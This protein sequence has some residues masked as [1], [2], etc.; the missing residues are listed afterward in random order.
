MSD[1]ANISNMLPEGLVF[2]EVDWPTG[3]YARKTAFYK[4]LLFFQDMFFSVSVFVLGWWLFGPQDWTVESIRELAICVIIGL[5]AISYLTAFNTYS[6]HLIFS[7]SNHLSMLLK[8]IGWGGVAIGFVHII[9]TWPHL[10]EGVLIIPVMLIFAGVILV[11]SRFYSDQLIS[12]LMGLGI[13]FIATGIL[14]LLKTQKVPII[15][16]DPWASP[17]CFLVSAIIIILGRLFTV[18]II[19]NQFLRKQFRRQIAI[20]GSDQDAREIVEHIIKNNAPFWVSGFI[21]NRPEQCGIQMDIDKPCLGALENLPAIAAENNINEIIV[22]DE[23]IDKMSLIT[24]LDFCTSQRI[25]VWFPSK[26]MPIIEMKLYIDNFC[27]IPMIRLGTNNFSS[28]FTGLKYSSD[29]I[30]TLIIFL[31]QLPI[32]MSIALAVKLTSKGP[33]F[34]RAKAIGKNGSNFAMLKF[35]SMYVDND[36]SI[37]KEFVTKLI[38]GEMGDSSGTKKEPLKIKDDPRVT[39]VGKII[40]K[41]SLDE[42]PQLL[43][44]LKG[45]MS[46]VGPRPCLPYEYEIYANWHKKR[47]CVRPGISGLW[48]V[49]GRSEVAFEDMILLDLY[50]IYNSSLALDFSILFETAFVVLGKKGAY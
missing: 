29:T 47:T 7:K 48:Q 50:Y 14:E 42:L 21:G 8:A 25:A 37:H 20:I 45:E 22:T 43:N 10:F 36:P 5:V 30:L 6:Y 18:Q 9:Y 41:L 46:L 24:I 1:S 13:S 2:N 35:R 28:A 11:L 12:L 26:L 39:T 4:L 34:Y 33:V 3:I 32:F 16:E 31:I 19:F 23:N 38:K 27:G 17:L 15:L 40:R 44:V 49:T